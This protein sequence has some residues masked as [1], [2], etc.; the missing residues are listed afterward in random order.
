MG[1]QTLYRP[2]DLSALT[3]GSGPVAAH[4]AA[5]L[6][7]LNAGWQFRDSSNVDSYPYGAKPVGI[8]TLEQALRVIPAD[9]PVLL[10]MNALPAQPRADAVAQL[11]DRLNAWS[12]VSIYSTEA[13]CQG[14]FVRYPQAHLF[15]ARDATRQRLFGVALTGRFD[16]L[17]PGARPAFELGRN[18]DIV[19]RFTLGE[20]R[21][22]FDARTWTRASVA[23]FRRGASYADRVRR[24]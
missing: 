10:D 11:L 13:A 14:A 19:E 2:A 4:S 7:R 9:M 5:G 8:T 21:S 18:V 20:G 16:A 23:C 15:G 12:R 6:A 17:A 22:S 3:N 24:Q 1:C